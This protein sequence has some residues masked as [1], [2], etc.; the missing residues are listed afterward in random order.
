MKEKPI[1]HLNL[2]AQW[3]DMI[4]AGI[5]K[6]EYREIKPFWSRVFSANIKIK[7]KYYH[8]TDVIICF[9]HAYTKDRRQMMIECNGLR[10]S[11]GVRLWGAEPSKQYYTLILGDK[12]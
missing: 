2:K 9:S 5:K 10:I 8:P 4:Y 3:Y 12:S 7:G 6:E 11:E 1:L